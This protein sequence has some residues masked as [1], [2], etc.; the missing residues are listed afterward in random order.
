MGR[1]GRVV[2]R[3]TVGWQNHVQPRIAYAVSML[4]SP[5]QLVEQWP[6]GDVSLGGRVALFVHF[7]GQGAVR[8]HVRHYL[9]ALHAAGYDI[10]FV[11]N[12]G[13]LQP[14]A[15]AFLQTLCTAILIRRNIGYD[16]G[17]V[18]EGLSRM[19]MPRANTEHLL[20]VNDSVY[21][22]LR[23]LDEMLAEI[24]FDVADIWGATES[25]QTR[26]HLQSFFLAVGPVAMGNRAWAAFW[27]SVRPVSSKAWIISR[28]EIGLTQRL[29][30]AGLRARAIF[31][32]AELVA[33]IDPEMLIQESEAALAS[34]DPAIAMR[35]NHARRIRDSAVL[36]LPLNPTSDLWR[37]LLHAGF[38]FLKREL[39][40][41]N[42][43]S[44]ADVTDWRTE[45]TEY[46]SADP[47]SIE[48]D[49]QRVL[50]NTAP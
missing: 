46:L 33:Q 42:P 26:Y 8:E 11:T 24:D 2:R 40:R 37:Q 5:E 1:L 47:T 34:S 29:I 21:G 35:K 45:V 49:L 18:R 10:A 19:Q 28:Y 14:E 23:P 22:P 4:R 41:D 6:K 16:F 43:T 3:L 25:W 31:R 20:I 32:Y 38:P 13:R 27:Q 15:M 36:R 48:R 30:R 17:A 39:L 7:D 9:A 44:V 50:R 12:A